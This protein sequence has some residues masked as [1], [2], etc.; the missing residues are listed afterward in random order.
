MG[1][2]K[3][4]VFGK[5]KVESVPVNT[6]IG[7]VASTIGTAQLLATRLS[8]SVS[9]ISLFSV[10]GSD[11]QCGISGTY[12][13]PDNCFGNNANITYF[14]D[15]ENRCVLLTNNAFQNSTNLSSVK[16]NGVTT[17]VGYDNFKGYN[18]VKEYYF[19][20]LTSIEGLDNFSNGQARNAD[21][22]YLP[23][24]LT[25]GAS[26]SVD[27]NTFL[28]V[29]GG[30]KLYVH[31]SIQTS[32]NG[33]VEADVAYAIS[34]GAIVRYVTNFT[35]PNQITNLSAGAIYNTAI[36]LNFTAPS[37]TNA[38]DY[39]EL[40]INGVFYKIIANGQYVTALTANTSYNFT[41]V[42]VDI[43]YNKSVVSNNLLV[44]TNS[45]TIPIYTEQSK[46]IHSLRQINNAVSNCIKV[47]RSSDSTTSIIGF[48]SGVL[49]ETSLLS[50]VG[51]GD[52]FVEIWYDQS[53]NGFNATQATLTKQPKI[54]SEGVV[55][56]LN[57]KPAMLLDNV[58]DGMLT[59][60]SIVRPYSIFAV[61]N[62][63]ASAGAIRMISSNTI[64]S[65]ISAT[66][67]DGFCVFTNGV[68]RNSAYAIAGE[69][70]LAE[71]IENTSTSKFYKNGVDSTIGTGNSDFGVLG[72]GALPGRNEKANGYLQ[73]CVVY[74]TDITTSKTEIELN[75]NVFYNIY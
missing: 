32:N 7:G 34:Q 58:D 25:F 40:H 19:P 30:Y 66:R 2:L 54:V 74:P 71:L 57:N 3:K 5:N 6:F 26:P 56:K 44:S 52:G 49:D 70:V 50:F 17:F 24:C 63:L 22:Y 10:V 35:P 53:G 39:Y 23:N 73:E 9:R 11:I 16:L 47:R 38:I 55:L 62:Q 37:S 60:A 21:V 18:L 1:S 61:F 64:N 15:N 42:S 13:M 36:K 68:V 31:P 75:M 67:N 20:V 69:R 65:L 59:T 27:N 51:T 45:T 48:V 43:F 33:G 12:N 72:F 4:Y 41:V 8:I 14:H 29:L 28:Y 46:T